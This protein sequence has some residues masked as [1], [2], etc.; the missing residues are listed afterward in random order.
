MQRLAA[1]HR[2]RF[3]IPVIG[4]TGSNGKTIVKEW[5]NQALGDRFAIVRSPKSYNSQIGVPLSVWQMNA[6]FTLALFEAGISRPGE[7]A[8]LQ[9]VIRPTIGIFTN[10]GEAHAEGFTDQREKIREKLQ[11][12]KDAKTLVYCRDVLT[13]HEEILSFRERLSARGLQPFETVGWSKMGYAR[14]SADSLEPFGADVRGLEK[15][16]LLHIRQIEKADG[17]TN[18]AATYGSALSR[19]SIPFTDDA[20]IENAIHCWCVLLYLGIEETAI[21]EQMAALQRKLD[22]LGG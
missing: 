5:L 14:S 3:S 19:I 6:S 11:L 13:I 2:S 12:F 18:L 8:R 4:I 21:Q 22:K 9:P 10:I 1:F 15:A 16:A 17:H 20:S 7:M